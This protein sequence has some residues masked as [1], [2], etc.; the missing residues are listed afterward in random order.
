MICYEFFYV[1]VCICC[2]DFDLVVC[3][4]DVGYGSVF[5]NVDVFVV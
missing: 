5:V 4:F 3:C 1:V 2:M